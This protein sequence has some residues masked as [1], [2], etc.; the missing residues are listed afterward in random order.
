MAKEEVGGCGGE[1]MVKVEA[2]EGDEINRVEW[3]RMTR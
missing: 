2:V 1:V 3:R